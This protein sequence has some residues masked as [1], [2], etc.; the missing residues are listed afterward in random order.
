MHHG[1]RKP[2]PEVFFS[3]LASLIL[4]ASFFNM[5]NDFTLNHCGELEEVSKRSYF[6][7]KFQEKSFS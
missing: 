6:E 5:L 2:V 3:R 1:G 4:S 7:R